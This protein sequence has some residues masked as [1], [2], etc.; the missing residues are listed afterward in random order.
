MTSR[1]IIINPVSPTEVLKLYLNIS[2]SSIGCQIY[3]TKIHEYMTLNLILVPL[4]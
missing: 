1:G 2:Y 4:P 3:C